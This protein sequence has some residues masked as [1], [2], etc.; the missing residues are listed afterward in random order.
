M[1]CRGAV[2]AILLVLLAM[3]ILPCSFQET[4]IGAS[5]VPGSLT[6]RFEPLQVCDQGDFF[7]GALGDLPVLVPGIPVLVLAPTVLCLVPAGSSFMPDGFRPTIDHPP[8][9]SA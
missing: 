3:E 1:K 9:L 5:G 7:L 8:Q 4:P 6:C 2:A